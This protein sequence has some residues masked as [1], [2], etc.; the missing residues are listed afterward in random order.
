MT[1]T[2]TLIP[3]ILIIIIKIQHPEIGQPL[4]AYA[5][6]THN[7]ATGQEDA[8]HLANLSPKTIATHI[9]RAKH[10]DITTATTNQ[11]EDKTQRRTTRKHLAETKYS[12]Q[13]RNS[14]QI[15]Q[16]SY[17]QSS[18]STRLADDTNVVREQSMHTTIAPLTRKDRIFNRGGRVYLPQQNHTLQNANN[19]H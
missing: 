8:R 3:S 7:T 4:Q 14:L 1:E 10:T 16:W 13:K 12:G 2:P 17:H 9:D 15:Q 11:T 6:T 18:P 5:V 19:P